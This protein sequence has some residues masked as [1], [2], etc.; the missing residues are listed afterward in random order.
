MI[1]TAT[2]RQVLSGRSGAQL[3]DYLHLIEQKLYTA[4]RLGDLPI[5]VEPQLPEC[6]N[7]GIV[8]EEVE[9][10]AQIGPG[11]LLLPSRK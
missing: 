5:W 8:V 6:V 10:L 11:R 9:H 7:G 2:D 1:T 3:L 4:E